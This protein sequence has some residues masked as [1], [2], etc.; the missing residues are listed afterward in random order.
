M[1]SLRVID[2][3][4]VTPAEVQQAGRRQVGGSV[5]LVLPWLRALA[6]GGG[7]T[8]TGTVHDA[9]AGFTLPRSWSAGQAGPTATVGSAA[10]AAASMGG[11][12]GGS[13]GSGGAADGVVGREDP[14]S[15]RCAAAVS[16]V[17]RYHEWMAFGK[18][19]LPSRRG[20][21]AVVGGG[22]RRLA[23]EELGF[24]WMC[25]AQRWEQKRA[26]RT[27]RKLQRLHETG[28]EANCRGAHGAASKVSGAGGRSVRAGEVAGWLGGGGST[29][30]GASCRGRGPCHSH[31]LTHAHA[32]TRVQTACALR[33]K[34]RCDAALLQLLARHLSEHQAVGDAVVD[35]TTDSGTD[36]T[37]RVSVSQWP[38]CHS[39]DEA[40][41]HAA[42][43]AVGHRGATLVQALWRG[44]RTRRQ[45]CGGAALHQCQRE[46]CCALTR[47][48]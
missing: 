5:S 2:G 16:A 17:R 48:R 29:V 6:C 32:H 33:I 46:P 10:A 25:D 24:Q 35:A 20:G 41:A 23:L 9:A 19:L 22:V 38:E 42:V 27:M 12:S 21:V 39:R 7:G 45:V 30:D 11:G 43:T 36:G 18:L 40:Y 4:D 26:A 13:G 15:P 28:H 1:P 34:D 31:T 3:V 37:R 44:R 14:G 8:G 47:V